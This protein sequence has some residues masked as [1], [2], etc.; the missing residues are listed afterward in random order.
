MRCTE[1]MQGAALCG[2]SATFDIIL[3]FEPQLS[4]HL[5]FIRLRVRY[6]D[7]L[8]LYSAPAMRRSAD[9]YALNALKLCRAR[10]LCGRSAPFDII[11]RFEPH[12]RRIYASPARAIRL[13]AP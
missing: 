12:Y 13:A 9:V 7:N 5:C 3:R 1:S 2:R 11:L 10:L 6:G 4:P 8:N